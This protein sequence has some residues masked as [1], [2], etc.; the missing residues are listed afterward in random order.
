LTQFRVHSG[1]AVSA[2]ARPEVSVLESVGVASEGD[3]FG[4]VDEPVDHGG[5]D[6]LVA[7]DFAPTYPTLN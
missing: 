7:E 4:V 2:G 1:S 3:D 5:G 6:D